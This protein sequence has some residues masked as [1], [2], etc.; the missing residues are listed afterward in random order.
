[1]NRRERR[2]AA[3][4]DKVDWNTVARRPEPRYEKVE[5]RGSLSGKVAEEVIDDG[6]AES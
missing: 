4:K 1:M 5:Y 2:A 3:R 6:Q